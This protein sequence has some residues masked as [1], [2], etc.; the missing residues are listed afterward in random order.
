MLPTQC[1]MPDIKS[2]CKSL[3]PTLVMVNTFFDDPERE[4]GLLRRL[5]VHWLDRAINEYDYAR[6]AI[7]D[8]IA[9]MQR[10]PEE[11]SQTGSIIYMLHFSD[12]IENCLI[13]TRRILRVLDKLKRVPLADID[14]E[15]RRYIDAHSNDFVKVRDA[16]E[17]VVEITAGGKLPQQGSL[18]A[19]LTLDEAGIEVGGRIVTF[20]QL[21]S[22]LRQFHAIAQKILDIQ[23]GI[24]ESST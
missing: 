6:D 5:L 4:F 15:K 19:N 10:T 14:R 18:L 3:R 20:N 9:E 8:Q 23:S 13:L 12:H 11:M 22:I 7:I 17:H 21:C 2:E 24:V 1:L 16:L